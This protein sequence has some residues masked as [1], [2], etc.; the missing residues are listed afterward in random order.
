MNDNDRFERFVADRFTDEHSGRP[1]Y[2]AL[3]HDIITRA[4]QLRQRP[5]WL[6]L[7]KEPPMRYASHPVAGSTTARVAAIAIATFLLALMLAGAG[8][9]GSRLLAAAAPIIVD[10]HDPGAVQTITEAVA[11][12][13]DGDT[14]LVRPGVYPES[15]VID[16]DITLKGDGEREAVVIEVGDDGPTYDGFWYDPSPYGILFDQS[17]AEVSGLT[18]RLLSPWDGS[19][20]PT[21]FVAKGGDPLIHDVYA[22][23]PRDGEPECCAGP[24]VYIHGGSSATVEDSLLEGL[25]FVQDESP[26]TIEDNVI[27]WYMVVDAGGAAVDVLGNTMDGVSYVGTGRIEGNQVALRDDHEPD[28]DYNGIHL[29]TGSLGVPAEGRWTVA[30]NDVRGVLRG[31]WV[32][33]PVAGTIA[34]NT[35][36][37][38]DIGMNL[39]GTGTGYTAEDNSVAGGRA[40]IVVA[41]GEVT[42][43]GNSVDGASGTGLAIFE[44]AAATLRGNHVCDNGTNLNDL[45]ESSDID[46]SNEICEDPPAE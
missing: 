30:D 6:A 35:L 19:V 7:I 11:M 41:S 4:G 39:S 12:A 17:D 21:G 27:G 14:V 9:A 2:D 40:G 22:D 15:V 28:V 38:N 36:A 31:I 42:L 32:A 33:T 24:S 34:R 23:H 1:S 25:V 3:H 20:G 26:A 45:S 10:Q 16:K 44:R 43:S 8:L 29:A 46:D 13:Q 5:R 18:V 37:D